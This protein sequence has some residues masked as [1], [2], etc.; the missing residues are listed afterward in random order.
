[1]G[2]DVIVVL[3]VLATITSIFA[4]T[5]SWAWGRY[6][7]SVGDANASSLQFTAMQLMR[8]SVPRCAETSGTAHSE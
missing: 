3:A 8:Q 1:M 4:E 6:A 7:T 2:R 5:R